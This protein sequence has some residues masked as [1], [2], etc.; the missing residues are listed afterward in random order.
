MMNELNKRL[1]NQSQLPPDWKWN[2]YED[3]SGSLRA[4]DGTSYFSYDRAPYANAGGIEYKREK[5]EPW[6]VYWGSMADFK[7]YAEEFVLNHI[8]YN[9]DETREEDAL[10]DMALRTKGKAR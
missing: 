4:P 3:G 7:A 9:N 2:D 1:D 6:D 10:P 8:M 5:G